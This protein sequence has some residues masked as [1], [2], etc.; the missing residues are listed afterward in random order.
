MVFRTNFTFIWIIANGAYLIMILWSVE[1]SGNKTKVNDGTFGYLEVFS[2]YLAALVVFRLVFAVLYILN[3]KFK[4]TCLRR[5]RIQHHDLQSEFKRI[6]GRTNAHGE[7]T[8]DEEME[9]KVHTIF[10]TNEKAVRKKMKK[11]GDA[12]KAQEIE[13]DLH[14]ATIE[15]MHDEQSAAPE[16]SDDDFREFAEADVE[17][18]EDRIYNEYKKR[19]RF[20]KG[21]KKLDDDEIGILARNVPV[22]DMD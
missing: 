19:K 7:S 8:D 4:Y 6:K 16:D 9:E 22:Q 2:L 1:G 14:E 20:G 15:F 10:K 17:E 21:A 3:W 12:E 18:A 5:Y 13:V 11:G